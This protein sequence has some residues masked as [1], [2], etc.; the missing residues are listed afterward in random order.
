MGKTSILAAETNVEGSPTSISFLYSLNSTLSDLVKI[1]LNLTTDA[2]LKRFIQLCN[3][4]NI[5][6]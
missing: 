3:T 1:T 2:S 4:F 6:K 5:T